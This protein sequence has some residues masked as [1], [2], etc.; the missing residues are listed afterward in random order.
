MEKT[1]DQIYSGYNDLINN[2]K[3]GEGITQ[4]ALY[5]KGHK[6]LEEEFPLTDYILGCRRVG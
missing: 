1:M 3:G 4:G 2:P 6:Y 5:Q